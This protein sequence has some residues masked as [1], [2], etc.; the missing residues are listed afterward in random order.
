MIFIVLGKSKYWI[1]YINM[2]SLNK[3]VMI[4]IIIVKALTF[5]SK[6]NHNSSSKSNGNSNGSSQNLSQCDSHLVMS[7]KNE[8][9]SSS[10][11]NGSSSKSPHNKDNSDCSHISE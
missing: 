5:S 8:S 7:R 9:D 2:N 6:T 10:K 1:A 3:I 11:S 4:N